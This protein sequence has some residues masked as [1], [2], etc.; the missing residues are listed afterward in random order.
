MDVFV[1]RVLPLL[2]VA[3]SQA[4]P[5]VGGFHATALCPPTQAALLTWRNNH[6]ISFGSAGEFSTSSHQ[7]QLVGRVEP[8]SGGQDG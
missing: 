8:M 4:D 5:S 1:I 7:V 2:T 6:A 3:C